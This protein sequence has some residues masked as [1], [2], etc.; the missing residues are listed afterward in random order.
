MGDRAVRPLLTYLAGRPADGRW[1]QWQIQRIGGS[2]NNILYRASGDD[3]DLAVKFTIRDARRRAQRE[4]N[5]LLAL[6]QAGLS[7]APLP[8]LLDETNYALPV[9]VPPQYHAVP[10]ARWQWVMALYAELAED[11]TAVARIQTYYPLMLVWWAARLARALYEVPRGLDERL[12]PRPPEW[13]AD[14]EAR[15]SY[16]VRLA[17]IALDRESI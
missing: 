13:R 1:L 17:T 3:A 16:Y 15:Y 4:Y 11:E 12:A 7:V 5:A 2:A 14:I 6:Q 9:N 8:I 10:M